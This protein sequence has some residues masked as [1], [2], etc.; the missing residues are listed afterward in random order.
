VTG[1]LEKA[2]VDRLRAVPDGHVRSSLANSDAG[3]EAMAEM[4]AASL[5]T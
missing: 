4:M 2:C 3:L 5:P 1:G